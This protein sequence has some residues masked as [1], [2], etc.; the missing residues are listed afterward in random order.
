VTLD[1][2]E[3]VLLGIEGNEKWKA[4]SNKVFLERAMRD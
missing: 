4:F 1:K 3:N 2:Q